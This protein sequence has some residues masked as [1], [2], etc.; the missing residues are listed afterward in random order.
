MALG[1]ILEEKEFETV[2][3]GLEDA[4]PNAFWMNCEVRFHKGDIIAY[5]GQGDPTR[6]EEILQIF[7]DWAKSEPDWLAVP[8]KATQEGLDR[9][10]WEQ[11][12]QDDGSLECA[13]EFC[14]RHRISFSVYCR[15]H[16][17]ESTRHKICPFE[18]TRRTTIHS[19]LSAV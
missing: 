11:L 1:T 16:H 17:F 4:A 14:Q 8:P 19:G 10:Y 13:D 5:I 2:R 7:L 6:L 18:E 3:K 9:M 15:K 12:P